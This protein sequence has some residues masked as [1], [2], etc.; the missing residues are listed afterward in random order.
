MAGNTGMP[1]TPTLL[2]QLLLDSLTYSGCFDSEIE[3]YKNILKDVSYK[4]GFEITLNDFWQI[5]RNATSS[6]YT[7]FAELEE[8]CIPNQVHAFLAHRLANRG[9]VITTNYDR[10]IEQEWAKLSSIKIRYTNTQSNSFDFWRDDLENGACLFK[11]HG[12]LDNPSSCLGALEHVGTQLAG[13]RADL[14]TDV[15]QNRPI[16]FVGWRGVD[17]DIPPL[18]HS[19]I[20]GRDT[21]LPI[22][23]IHYEGDP[24]GSLTLE[25]T[26]QGMPAF[27]KPLASQNP[28]LTDAD[29]AFGEMLNWLGVNRSPNPNKEVLSFDFRKPV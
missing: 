26:I 22:F 14:L 15:M 11:I 4:L 17:P 5:C 2:Y 28:I 1:S 16:C 27:I 8:Q 19:A 29:R 6:L 13:D 7:T 24:P 25:Q 21:S 20:E 18:L 10:L 12:S 9:T 23:W 3:D